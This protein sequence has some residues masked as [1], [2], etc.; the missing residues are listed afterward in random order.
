MAVAMRGEEAVAMLPEP[1]PEFF[2][3]GLREFESVQSTARE[4]LKSAFGMNGGKGF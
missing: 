1:G 3:V 2:T 4:E